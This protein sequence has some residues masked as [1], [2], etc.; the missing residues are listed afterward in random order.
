MILY[1]N[2][3]APGFTLPIKRLLIRSAVC[4][5]GWDVV[6]NKIPFSDFHAHEHVSTTAPPSRQDVAEY[7]HT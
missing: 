2:F 7:T 5:V 6:C 1:R 3:T 4:V